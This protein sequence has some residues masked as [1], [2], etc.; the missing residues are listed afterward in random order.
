MALYWLT[1]LTGRP[2]Q[3]AP[4]EIVNQNSKIA[5]QW[6][7]RTAVGSSTAGYFTAVIS[8]NL[9]NSDSIITLAIQVTGQASSAIFPAMPTVV[10]CISPGGF[11]TLGNVASANFLSA[12]SVSAITAMWEIKNP[13]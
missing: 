13:K 3:G 5:N 9:V 4:Q 11:F 1:K 12:G 2:V 10:T 8:T 7:G 6:F